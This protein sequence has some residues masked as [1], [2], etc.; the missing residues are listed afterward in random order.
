M[1]IAKR[2]EKLWEG[3]RTLNFDEYRFPNSRSSEKFLDYVNT[4]FVK[5]IFSSSDSIHKID[6]FSLT[7]RDFANCPADEWV[8]FAVS[9]LH[10]SEVDL[11]SLVLRDTSTLAY[12]KIL[13][14]N[15]VRFP[16][17]KKEILLS[18]R[19]VESLM[20]ED[21]VFYNW[22]DCSSTRIAK[23]KIDAP[24]LK[25]LMVDNKSTKFG[26]GQCEFVLLAPYLNSLEFKGKLFKDYDLG[27]FTSLVTA[28]VR[29]LP[30]KE[31]KNVLF[32]CLRK[33]L[34]GISSVKSLILGANAFQ[35]FAVFLS[36]MKS[37]GSLF[38]NLKY[39][40]LTNWQKEGYI[41]GLRKLLMYVPFV[42][43]IVLET[44]QIS[45]FVNMKDQNWE[46]ELTPLRRFMISHLKTMEVQ[47]ID[48]VEID[49]IKIKN[50]NEF[51]FIAFIMKHAP[52]LDTVIIRETRKIIAH[53][54]MKLVGFCRAL[55]KEAYRSVTIVLMLDREVRI[56]MKGMEA[57][58]KIE[59]GAKQK[60]K[61]VRSADK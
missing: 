44:A 2:W 39:L 21:L 34:I 33:I 32:A 60:R 55:Q 38:Q 30:D 4:V 15:S 9:T 42:E 24:S 31:V 11:T 5:L 56:T 20:M 48:V 28:D 57:L 52:F 8:T 14:L 16:I 51:K 7:A 22:S 27:N 41:V 46:S 29:I 35:I 3:T 36:G 19:N 23:L 40:K 12:V 59:P 10:T 13:R 54:E 50:S 58:V 61:I 25:Y 18:L 45:S 1:V 6:K 26:C 49:S 53:E 17:A 37:K 47:N 43:T